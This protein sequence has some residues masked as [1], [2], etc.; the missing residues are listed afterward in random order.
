MFDR[1]TET[2]LLYDFYGRLLTEKQ[3]DVMNLYHQEN[4]SLSEISSEYGISRQAVHISLKNAEKSLLGYEEK[5]G[6]MKRFAESR[7]AILEI[8]KRLSSIID[9]NNCDVK[10]NEELKSIKAIIDNLE[11]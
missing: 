5:L 10:L 1:L 3:R 7:K 6:L 9:K 4:Y 2:S 11:I 8:D